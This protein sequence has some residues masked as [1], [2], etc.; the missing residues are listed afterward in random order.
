[1]SAFSWS[2]KTS[3]IREFR[4]HGQVKL[5]ITF[6]LSLVTLTHFKGCGRFFCSSCFE[7][8]LTFADFVLDIFVCFFSWL[9]CF[10]SSLVY[11]W[12]SWF[13][14]LLVWDEQFSVWR[15]KGI[16]SKTILPP[17][18]G[19]TLILCTL[20][21]LFKICV[22]LSFEIRTCSWTQVC[23]ITTGSYSWYKCLSLG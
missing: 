2:V 17:Y 3:V 15:G 16:V 6:I 13:L 4:D 10:V 19:F 14:Y 11:M 1:M 8:E 12:Y 20:S 7:C 5:K 9:W 21:L 18:S 23:D 22:S